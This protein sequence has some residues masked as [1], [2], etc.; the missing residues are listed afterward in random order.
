MA[1]TKSRRPSPCTSKRID[2]S[3]GHCSLDCHDLPRPSSRVRSRTSSMLREGRL[4]TLDRLKAAGPLSTHSWSAAHR[5][6][7]AKSSLSA[8]GTNL[9]VSYFVGGRSAVG[10]G[11][12]RRSSQPPVNRVQITT[13]G[14]RAFVHA[15]VARQRKR[16]RR[17]AE[18][19]CGSQYP[20][21]APDK[22]C[23]DDDCSTAHASH[24]RKPRH[25]ASPLLNGALRLNDA[26]PNIGR[27]VA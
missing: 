23:D 4:T 22:S 2:R 25:C 14:H 12:H 10:Y 6:T 24:R 17:D 3:S 27:S 16:R 19:K 13:E 18:A 8:I 21:R 9:I 11:P 26:K 20:D 1:P 15:P 5:G 7:D